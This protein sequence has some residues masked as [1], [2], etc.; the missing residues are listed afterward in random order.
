M[1]VLVV[2]VEFNFAR[3]S[4]ENGCIKRTAGSGTNTI[5]INIDMSQYMIG[6]GFTNNI[7]GSESGDP[8]GSGQDTETLLGSMLRRLF[9]LSEQYPELR[10]SENFQ[11]LQSQLA[12]AENKIAVSRQIYNDTVLTYNNSIQTIPTNVIASLAGFKERTYFEV[13]YDA[14]SAPEVQF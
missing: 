11:A 2:N 5:P 6:T 14:R 10:A 7:L 12:E 4:I 8:L 3:V 9:A 13:E 1:A